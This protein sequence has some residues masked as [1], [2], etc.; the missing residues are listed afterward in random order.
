MLDQ[1]IKSLFS[2]NEKLNFSAIEVDK[3]VKNI[4]AK[5]GS[6]AYVVRTQ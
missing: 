6:A 2:Y 1:D 5:T 3:T 4:S